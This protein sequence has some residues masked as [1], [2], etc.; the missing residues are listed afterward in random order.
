[1]WLMALPKTLE[2]SN[3]TTARH[4]LPRCHISP[5]VQPRSMTADTQIGSMQSRT[6]LDSLRGDCAMDRL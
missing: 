2:M 1:M 5:S 3:D 4:S 6:I